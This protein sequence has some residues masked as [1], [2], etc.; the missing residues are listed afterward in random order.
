MFTADLGVIRYCAEEVQRQQDTPEAV[1]DMV[2]AWCYAQ[3]AQAVGEDLSLELIITLGSLVSPLNP[4]DSFRSM[5]VFVGDR[6]PPDPEDVYRLMERYI[7][8]LPDMSPEEAYK[9]FEMIHPFRD[10]NGR[11]GKIIYNWL[12]GTLDKPAM[13]PNFWGIA[14]P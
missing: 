14:N 3:A 12:R 6:I 4:D 2:E 1:A 8:N 5:R 10:G 7:V 9:E 13:P 11:T